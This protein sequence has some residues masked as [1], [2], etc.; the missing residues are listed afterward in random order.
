MHARNM[1]TRF[2][3]FFVNPTLHPLRLLTAAAGGR[4]G[5]HT[6]VMHG[7]RRMPTSHPHNAGTEHVT[8]SPTRKTSLAPSATRREVLVLC[9]KQRRTGTYTGRTTSTPTA[10]V[11]Q[12]S[13]TGST[14]GAG[15]IRSQV[16]ACFLTVHTQ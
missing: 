1:N 10:A 2:G 3:R 4:G 9:Y 5:G 7:R 13:R 11:Y 6:H 12:V 16:E 14:E 15:K 8:F